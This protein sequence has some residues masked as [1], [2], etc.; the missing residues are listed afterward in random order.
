[1]GLGPRR[2]VIT[3]YKV[4]RKRETIRAIEC[5]SIEAQK[6]S[7]ASHLP[8]GEGVKA[9]GSGQAP[10]SVLLMMRIIMINHQQGLLVQRSNAKWAHNLCDTSHR[11]KRLISSNSKPKLSGRYQVF[12]LLGLCSADMDP[13]SLIFH[14]RVCSRL[15]GNPQSSVGSNSCQYLH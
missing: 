5:G 11:K 9:V 1:M 10:F 2:G 12:A 4:N 7:G 6:G 13:N 14:N 15:N 3:T 8:G